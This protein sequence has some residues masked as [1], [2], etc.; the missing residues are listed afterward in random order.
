MEASRLQWMRFSIAG[1]FAALALFMY[2]S[3]FVGYDDWGIRNSWLKWPWIIVFG[4]LAV[5]ANVSWNLI[6]AS[7]VFLRPPVFRDE[8]GNLSLFFTT[9]ITK[10]RKE[11]IDKDMSDLYAKLINQ[12]VPGHFED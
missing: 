7:F 2:G 11:G 9:R 6:G 4:T 10:Y 5:I 8:D 3:Y 1:P 12:W